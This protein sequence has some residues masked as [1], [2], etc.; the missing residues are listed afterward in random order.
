MKGGEARGRRRRRRREPPLNLF[1]HPSLHT[2]EN[3]HF[4]KVQD[5]KLD[6]LLGIIYVPIIVT[7]RLFLHFLYFVYL[8]CKFNMYKPTRNHSGAIMHKTYRICNNL[9]IHARYMQA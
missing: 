4:K 8:L 2:P 5:F 3:S 9:K 1:L 6:W 7:S